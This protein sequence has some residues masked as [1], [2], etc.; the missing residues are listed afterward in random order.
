[1]LIWHG[2]I[3]LATTQLATSSTNSKK[4][5]PDILMVR[6]ITVTLRKKDLSINDFAPVVRKK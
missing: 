1:M 6:A 5:V 3:I 2:I 4:S